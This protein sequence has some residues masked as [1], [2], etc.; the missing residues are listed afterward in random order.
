MNTLEQQIWQVIAPAVEDLSLRLVRVRISG[1][2]TS[3]TLQIM[4]EPQSSTPENPVGLAVDDV[5]KAT[6][7]ISALMDV[8]DLFPDAYT[9]EVSSPGVDRPLV[10]KRDFEVYAGK[11]IKVE[12]T[13]VLNDRRRFSGMLLG[14]EGEN[15]VLQEESMG[16]KVVLPFDLLKKSK[17]AFTQAEL[18]EI[19]KAKMKQS[20]SA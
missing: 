19:F 16:E 20:K 4:V 17:L 15:I 9:M 14:M 8:E 3:T 12:L 10:T 7:A 2:D 13:E 5:T 1:G 6:K 18:D 11:R